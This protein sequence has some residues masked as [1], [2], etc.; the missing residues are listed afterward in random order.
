MKTW[1][2]ILFSFK[3]SLRHYAVAAQTDRIEAL[4]SDLTNARD[5]EAAA[6]EKLRAA[7][8]VVASAASAAAA[9]SDADVS[10]QSDRVADLDSRA[11]AENGN[12]E[13]EA[14]SLREAL[15]ASRE[16]S[17]RQELQRKAQVSDLREEMERQADVI[18]SAYAGEL[19]GMRARL[20]GLH[21][22]KSVVDP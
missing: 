19:E 7:R 8:A 1:F 11:A 16:L 9:A 18:S 10:R 22:L 4:R 14:L 20:V 6:A 3:F 15:E 12:N 5:G 21:K 13:D 2:Q 17:R